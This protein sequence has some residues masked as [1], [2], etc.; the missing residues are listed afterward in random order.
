LGNIEELHKRYQDQVAFV[1]VYI[2]EAHPRG[3]WADDQFDIVQ[4]TTLAE[5]CEVAKLCCTTQKVTMPVV[6]DEI[7]DRVSHAYKA[8]PAQLYIVDDAGKFVYLS[9]AVRPGEM[10]QALIMHLLDRGQTSRPR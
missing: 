8:V 1:F 5:R 2:R 10:E 3:N 7:D 4:P 6:V 9:R